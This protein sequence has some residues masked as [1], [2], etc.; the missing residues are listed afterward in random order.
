MTHIDFYILPDT[1]SDARWHFVCRLIDK[2]VRMG[3]RVLVTMDSQAEAQELDELLWTF[4]PESFIPHQCLNDKRLP[5]T[6][7]EICFGPLQTL[8]QVLQQTT[9]GDHQ[10][11]LINLSSGIPADFSRFERLSEVVIQAADILKNTRDH[12]S[13]YRERGYPIQHRKM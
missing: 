10:G 9:P 2:A 7:V 4:K 12:Y 13:F 11:L 5:G 8:Q 1:S 6:P 3:H